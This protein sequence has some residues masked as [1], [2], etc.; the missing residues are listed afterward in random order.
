MSEYSPEV[1]AIFEEIKAMTAP[2]QLRLAA[3]LLESKRAD[4]AYPIISRV[5]VELGAALAFARGK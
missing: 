2:D 1:L 4:M 3:Q 5:K